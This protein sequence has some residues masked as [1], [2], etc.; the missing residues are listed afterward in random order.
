MSD[1][2]KKRSVLGVISLALALLAGLSILVIMGLPALT[3]DD[4]DVVVGPLLSLLI[5]PA[6]IVIGI[7][8]LFQRSIRF[9][10]AGLILSILFSVISI[11]IVLKEFLAEVVKGMSAV[12]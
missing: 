9:G 8:A 11:L 2:T 5:A 12:R 10:L 1:V 7:I 3:H 4:R 6:G